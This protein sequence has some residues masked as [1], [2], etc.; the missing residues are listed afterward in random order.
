[1]DF[2]HPAH[3]VQSKRKL[4]QRHDVPALTEQVATTA[5]AELRRICPTAGANLKEDDD[6]DTASEGEAGVNT[7]VLPTVTYRWSPSSDVDQV[8]FVHARANKQPEQYNCRPDHFCAVG[9]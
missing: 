1:M 9:A 2:S 3:G 7:E 5:F 8:L 6:T 4:K